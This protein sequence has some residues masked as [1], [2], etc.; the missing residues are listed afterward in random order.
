MKKSVQF[1]GGLAAVLM[2]SKDALAHHPLN[3]GVPGNV[4]E[5]LVS[6]LAHPVIGIDHLAFIL[7][8]G[9]ATAF[10]ARSGAGILALV[11]G[12]IVGCG[13]YLATV[14]LPASEFLVAL[15]VL[16]LG[17][18]V[19]S[20]KRL[21]DAVAVAGLFF[22]ALFHGFAYG[23]GIFGAETTPLVAYLIGFVAVQALIMVAA[24]FIARQVGAMT[25]EQTMGLR[26]SG[27]MLGG[28][29]L[30]FI[31]EHVEAFAFAM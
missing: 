28:I 9:L 7:L 6:G 15:S 27:A 2:A 19:M 8:A 11:A 12:T 16:I 1:L 30:T 5:G 31:L 17:V 13:A 4:T 20:G 3:G 10:I 22:A 21:S 29:G 14:T 24:Q 23:G 26:L 18:L 25:R